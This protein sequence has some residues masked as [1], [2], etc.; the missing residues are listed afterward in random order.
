MGY[1]KIIGRA[2]ALLSVAA[3]IGASPEVM[4]FA[5]QRRAAGES[6]QEAGENLEVPYGERSYEGIDLARLEQLLGQ[7]ERACQ[8]QGAMDAAQRQEAMEMAQGQES[9][10]D[11]VLIYRQVLREVDWAATQ[12]ALADILYSRNMED[13]ALASQ[14]EEASGK[15]QEAMEMVL[16]GFQRALQMP[17]GA[18]LETEMGPELAGAV[19]DYK[20][21][22]ERLTQLW[23][24]EL[25]LMLRYNQV[26]S[27]GFTVDV[28]GREWNYASLDEAGL[29]YED[30]YRIYMELE[31]ENNRRLGEIY[32][33]LVQVRNQIAVENGYDTYS[34]YAYE[35]VYGRDF[36]PQDTEKLYGPIKD[37]ALLLLED[38]WYAQYEDVSE[39]VSQDTE[40]LLD[41]L[42]APH[43]PLRCGLVRGKWKPQRELYH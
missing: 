19:K 27:E 9:L 4:V 36:T 29:G 3:L 22:S 6:R 26:Y 35:A 30:Y 2:A 5:G 41:Q 10:G 21:A 23:D 15:T 16:V 31:K 42:Y 18:A 12:M 11:P 13:E 14:Y 32:L 37:S 34:A 1:G 25:E 40:E 43:G 7:L 24:Q 20:P 28:D 38:C 17:G 33:D 39:A 8:G